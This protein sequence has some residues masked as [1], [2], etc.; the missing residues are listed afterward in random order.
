[1]FLKKRPQSIE[2]KRMEVQK[3]GQESSRGGKDKEGKEIEEG[4]V[5]GRARM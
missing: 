4:A 5:F 2:N 3:E 1:V